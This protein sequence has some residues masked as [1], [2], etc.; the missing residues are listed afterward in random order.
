VLAKPIKG[1]DHS[2][3]HFCVQSKDYRI[4][5][6]NQDLRNS[7]L[8]PVITE[9]LLLSRVSIFYFISFLCHIV[10]LSFGLQQEDLNSFLEI[11]EDQR[12]NGLTQNNSP[13]SNSQPKSKSESRS[14]SRPRGQSS[15]NTTPPPNISAPTLH[16]EWQKLM[17]I[18]R[19]FRRLYLSRQSP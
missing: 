8:N 1:S 15:G 14:K 18:S 4:P 19:R 11:A 2:S 13:S 10:T 12:V 17:T 3:F 5:V 7:C 9:F 16:Q 6:S